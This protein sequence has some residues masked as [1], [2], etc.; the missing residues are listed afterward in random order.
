MRAQKNDVHFI[1]FIFRYTVDMTTGTCSCENGKDGSPC[2][3]QYVL[4]SANLASCINFVPVSQPAMR[5][6]LAWIAIERS[7]PI[8]LYNNLRTPDDS[9]KPTSGETDMLELLPENEP[10]IQP[11][12]SL[13]GVEEELTCEDQQVETEDACI[14]LAADALSKSCEQ[15]MQKLRSTKDPNLAK[16]ILKFS[17]RVAVLSASSTMHS[18][19]VT[20]VFNFGS[21]E[22]LK[23][24][25]GKKIKVQPNRK[26]KS[27]NGSRQAVA[28]GRPTQM[29]SLEVPQKKAKRRHTLAQAVKSNTQSS[30]KSGS[31]VMKSKTK[32]F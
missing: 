14:D 12:N 8:S 7:L 24:G 29:H 2:K 30:K 25:K 19:L 26:R 27:G 28:K 16:G 15:I 3:H 6:K 10:A 11:S 23:K 18:N 22:I 4:W 32:H 13:S 21:D 9:T 1:Y 5:Q 17:K 20:A 31:H